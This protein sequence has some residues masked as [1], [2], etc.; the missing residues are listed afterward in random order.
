[1]DRANNTRHV[2]RASPSG[3]E[4]GSVLKLL[5]SRV[6]WPGLEELAKHSLLAAQTRAKESEALAWQ[7][8]RQTEHL[9]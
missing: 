9:F 5:V 1:M 6:E 2:A 4:A 8:R 3:V 7:R